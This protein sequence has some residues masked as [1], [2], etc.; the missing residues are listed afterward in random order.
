MNIINYKTLAVLNVDVHANMFL[1]NLRCCKYVKFLLTQHKVL[2][3]I[4]LILAA[5]K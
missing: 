4:K 5:G 1:L 3:K 2:N